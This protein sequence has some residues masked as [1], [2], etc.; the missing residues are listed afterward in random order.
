[1]MTNDRIFR[2]KKNLP[3][4][5]D[6]TK[7]ITAKTPLLHLFDDITRKIILIQFI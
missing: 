5:P 2:V 7:V 4:F 3:V 1:M 6:S